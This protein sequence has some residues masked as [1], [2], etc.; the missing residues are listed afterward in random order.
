M[1][2]VFLLHRMYEVAM[3]EYRITGAD[4]RHRSHSLLKEKVGVQFR[5]WTRSSPSSIVREE[6]GK[7]GT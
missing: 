4:L 7:I 2:S 6:A 3:P 1:S 5:R